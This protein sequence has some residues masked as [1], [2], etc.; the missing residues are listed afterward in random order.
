VRTRDHFNVAILLA[1]V[2]VLVAP[3]DLQL[4]R[5]ALAFGVLCC[6]AKLLVRRR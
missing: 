3:I 1:V 4:E 5:S 2:L 6:M